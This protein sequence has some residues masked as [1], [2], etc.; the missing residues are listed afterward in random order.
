MLHLR[1]KTVKTIARP[2]RHTRPRV[3]AQLP[4]PQPWSHPMNVALSL[5]LADR[6]LIG[7]H[8]RLEA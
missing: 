8:F 5:P 3:F 6:L 1:A 2:P 4:S 7:L